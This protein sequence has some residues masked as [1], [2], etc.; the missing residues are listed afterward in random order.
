[1]SFIK[2][3]CILTIERALSDHIAKSY[4]FFV[5]VF[6]NK[7]KH[8]KVSGPHSVSQRITA[9]QQILMSKMHIACKLLK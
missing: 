3:A 2:F 8:W 5:L 4:L 1:M 7:E 6:F 9:F